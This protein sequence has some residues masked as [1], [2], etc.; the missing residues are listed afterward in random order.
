MPSS[1]QG[2][3]EGW[4]GMCS[5][6]FEVYTFDTCCSKGSD[7]LFATISNYVN[8]FPDFQNLGGACFQCNRQMSMKSVILQREMCRY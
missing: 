5:V 7:D 2:G 1:R 3:L 8:R 6:L 4:L